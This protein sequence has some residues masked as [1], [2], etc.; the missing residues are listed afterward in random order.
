MTWLWCKSRLRIVVAT[1]ESPNPLPHPLAT[2]R[3]ELKEQIRGIGLERQASEFV[4]R[5]TATAEDSG[6]REESI[7]G[8]QAITVSGPPSFDRNNRDRCL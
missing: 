3:D 8:G 6:T 4:D 7:C 2:P 1:T 5:S